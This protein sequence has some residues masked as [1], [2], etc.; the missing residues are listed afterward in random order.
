MWTNANGGR[1]RARNLGAS[2]Q[3]PGVSGACLLERK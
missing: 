2:Q 1:G 3:R